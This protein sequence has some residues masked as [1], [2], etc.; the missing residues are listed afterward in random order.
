MTLLSREA[1]ATLSEKEQKFVAVSQLGYSVTV[2]SLQKAA[3][4]LAWSYPLCCSNRQEH[5]RSQ[6]LQVEAG[7]ML[8][9]ES[10]LLVFDIE[11]AWQGYHLGK[12]TVG[13]LGVQE[14]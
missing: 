8:A 7:T 9:A 13:V 14:A 10:G 2:S 12:R 3:D 6:A 5:S 1:G 4:Q 11:E